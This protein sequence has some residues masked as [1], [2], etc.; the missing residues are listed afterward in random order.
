M[1]YGG[2]G[3]NVPWPHFQ[4]IPYHVTWGAANEDAGPISEFIEAE[5]RWMTREE[6][7]EVTKFSRPRGARAE[8]QVVVED[9]EAD[10][11]EEGAD[12]FDEEGDFEVKDA[13]DEEEDKADGAEGDDLDDEEDEDEDDDMLDDDLDD[14]D[15]DNDDDDDDDDDDLDDML[16]F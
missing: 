5:G 16:G 10:D 14:D 1:D 4:D 3:V 11:D 8:A 7:E 9:E 6:E 2:C 13:L 12:G 15:D